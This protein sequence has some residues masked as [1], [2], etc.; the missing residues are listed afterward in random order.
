[1]AITRRCG[2]ARSVGE[3]EFGD[4]VADAPGDVL[5]DVSHVGDV[6]AG[7]VGDVPVLVAFAGED[8]A[9]VAAAHGDDHVGGPDD[10][11][12]P[13]FGELGADV[14]ADFGHGVDRGRVDLAFGH[15]SAGV[16]DDLIAGQAL[17][18]GG[19]HLGAAGV[20]DAQEQHRWDGG[21]DASLD[22]GQ[23]L[24]P[25]P[26]ESFGEDGEEGQHRGA[27]EELVEAVG[28]ESLD[29]LGGEDA[30]EFV[31]EAGGGRLD[32]V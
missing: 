17:E 7:W 3:L 22:L 31:F 16:D 24:Q 2:T 18:P 28:D 11:V 27:G 5:A 9:G 10:F 12:G 30:G 19:R 13:R 8:R 6:A 14:D 15:G 25:V 32:Q 20:V 21:F 29:G 1:A 4:E 23:G 26:G